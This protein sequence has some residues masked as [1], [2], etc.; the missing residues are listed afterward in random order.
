MAIYE[1]RVR[2]TDVDV[3]G[4]GVL[5]EVRRTLNIPKLKLVRTAK[6]YRLEGITKKQVE[7]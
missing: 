7:L 6:V 5:H 1:I 4:E 3:I 2:Q